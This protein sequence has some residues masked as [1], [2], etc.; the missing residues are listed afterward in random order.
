MRESTNIVFNSKQL[1]KFQ[2]NIAPWGRILN[3]LLSAVV[4]LQET[5]QNGEKISE[6]YQPIISK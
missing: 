5:Y 4:Y 3:L 2:L 6:K 1:R